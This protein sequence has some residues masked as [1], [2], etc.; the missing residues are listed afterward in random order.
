MRRLRIVAHINDLVQNI[1][2]YIETNVFFCEITYKRVG[3][4]KSPGLVGISMNFGGGNMILAIQMI[5][6]IWNNAKKN[7]IESGV[8]WVVSGL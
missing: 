2:R 6:T 8:F 4:S 3:M 7:A 5:F 1:V